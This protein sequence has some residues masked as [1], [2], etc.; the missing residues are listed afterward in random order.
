MLKS[1]TLKKQSNIF[2]ATTIFAFVALLIIF[3]SCTTSQYVL[4][5]QSEYDTI[6]QEYRKKIARTIDPKD[7]VYYE[8]QLKYH[9]EENSSTTHYAKK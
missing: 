1:L 8:Q 2:L 5:T 3:C 7:R 6:T 4:S 9:L